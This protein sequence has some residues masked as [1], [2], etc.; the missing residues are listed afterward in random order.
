MAEHSPEPWTTVPDVAN[1]PDANASLLDVEGR[2]LIRTWIAGND[3]EPGPQ[4]DKLIH[5]SQCRW[6]A[7]AFSADDAQRICACVNALKGIP[8]EALEAGVVHEFI[9][10]RLLGIDGETCRP[11]FGIVLPE[12]DRVDEAAALLKKHGGS[13]EQYT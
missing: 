7:A 8:T 11:G 13:W 1:D 3:D 10:K 6:S 5:E 12:H 9:G 2:N 4:I